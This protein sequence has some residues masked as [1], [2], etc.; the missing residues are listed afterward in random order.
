MLWGFPHTHQAMLFYTS[1]VSYNFL[2]LY[3]EIASALRDEG[4]GPTRLSDTCYLR[5]PPVL[6]TNQL[7]SRS[8]HGPFLRFGSFTAEAHRT[9]GSPVPRRTG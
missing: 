9:Q 8:P 7:Q 4:L 1:W 5:S 2:T 6:L 3:L